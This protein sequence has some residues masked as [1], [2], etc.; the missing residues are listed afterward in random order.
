MKKQPV[1][2]RLLATALV[3]GMVLSPVLTVTASALSALGVKTGNRLF[4]DVT[5]RYDPADTTG[6]F[7][8]SVKKN[9]DPDGFYWVFVTFG[10]K[11]VSDLHEEVGSELDLTDFST[12]DE[13]KAVADRLR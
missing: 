11:T 8:D 9:K 7:N 6:K 12:T 4:E 1:F 5:G 3:L 13:A 10:G 2:K